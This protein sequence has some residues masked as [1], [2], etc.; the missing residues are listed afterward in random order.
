MAYWSDVRYIDESDPGMININA[1]EFKRLGRLADTVLPE[2]A[3]VKAG[4][5][6]EGAGREGYDRKLDDVAR[7]VRY[8]GDAFVAAGTALGDYVPKLK[9]AKDLLVEGQAQEKELERLLKSIRSG[10]PGQ[11]LRFSHLV[12]SNE[13]LRQ[14]EDLRGSGNAMP[15]ISGRLVIDDD[16]ERRADRLYERIHQLFGDAKKLEKNA[17]S[18]CVAALHRAYELLPDYRRTDSGEGGWFIPADAIIRNI[19][20]LEQE[21]AEATADPHVRLPGMGEIPDYPDGTRL[22]SAVSPALQDLRERAAAL[23]GGNVTWNTADFIRWNST[24]DITRG[25]APVEGESEKDFKLRWIRDN[26][27]VINSAAAQY[28]IPA[29]VLAGIAYKEVGGKPLGLDDTTDW[30][31][32]H[33]PSWLRD[34]TPVEGDPDRTSYGPMAV[35]VRRA[36]EVLGYDPE[37]LSERQR[38][39]IVGSLKD[40]KENVFI[41]AQYLSNLKQS[42]DFALTDPGQMTEEQGQELAARY[43]G[44]PHWNSDDAQGYARDYAAHRAEAAEALK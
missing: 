26:R 29:N 42:S 16:M 41:A 25:G 17:R 4:T 8:L 24:I 19:P 13:P 43:N 7:L 27:E 18:D 23:P 12:T 33:L 30:M 37:S 31:R 10:Y 6:W 38:D 22:S 2:L 34:G 5:E 39:E 32:Q 35:Q 14:W 15:L 3:A 21:L 20:G 1:E 36:A 28:G 9:K 44:G 11:F 40:P